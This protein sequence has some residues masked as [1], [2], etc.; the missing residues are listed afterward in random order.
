MPGA[1][2]TAPAAMDPRRYELATLAAALELR[3]SYCALAHGK[4]LADAEVLDAVGAEP[5]P[6]Y[7]DLDY[8]MRRALTVG[9]PIQAPEASPAS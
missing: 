6:A 3:S 2:A 7:R 5:D 1:G 4:V 9:R 8:E